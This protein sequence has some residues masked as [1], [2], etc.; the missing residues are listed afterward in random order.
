MEPWSPVEEGRIPAVTSYLYGYYMYPACRRIAH[1]TYH[2]C[3][4]ERWDTASKHG[5]PNTYQLQLHA[6]Q[7][8]S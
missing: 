7:L 3:I 4:N 2:S 5:K 1:H 6:P 8:A